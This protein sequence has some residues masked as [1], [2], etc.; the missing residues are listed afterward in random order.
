MAQSSAPKPTLIE[1]PTSLDDIYQNLKKLLEI[2]P[3]IPDQLNRNTTAISNSHSKSNNNVN[4]SDNNINNHMDIRK[5]PTVADNR[6][7]NGRSRPKKFKTE[8][9]E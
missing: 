5:K 2:R 7:K 9:T 3:C 1:K 6:S 4:T 8:T